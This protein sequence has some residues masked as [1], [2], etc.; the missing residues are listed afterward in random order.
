VVDQ[1]D[2]ERAALALPNTQR[3]PGRQ[4]SI[5]IT[6]KPKPRPFV[7]VW[8]ERIHPKQ[9]R[10]PNPAVIAIRTASLSDKEMLLA[11][12]PDK[13][14]TEPHYDGYCAVMV[15]L[16]A[17]DRREL[18]SLLAGAWKAQA[19]KLAPARRRATAGTPPSPSTPA[20]RA[21]GSGTAS[22]PGRSRRSRTR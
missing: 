14:F 15:R 21:T 11:S 7:W 4:W 1:A 22:K 19:D 3:M 10:V 5:G 18:K 17:I 8:L 12:D 9:G 2:V 13:F 6:A 20:G 16:A